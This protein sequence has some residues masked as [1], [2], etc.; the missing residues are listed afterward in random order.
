MITNRLSYSYLE[1][2]KAG[3][4]VRQHGICES[5]RSLLV[6]FWATV[7][8][9]ESRKD[10]LILY[11][12]SELKKTIYVVFIRDALSLLWRQAA[13]KGNYLP[14]AKGS[15]PCEHCCRELL[16]VLRSPFSCQEFS[17]KQNQ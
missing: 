9:S 7:T 12:S 1:D 6:S 16:R 2:I 17:L 3:T 14:R 5:R 8:D 4:L 11:V 13:K 10:W 15:F